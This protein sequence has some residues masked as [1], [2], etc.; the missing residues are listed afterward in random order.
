LAKPVPGGI[1]SAGFVE[2]LRIPLGK[3]T[4]IAIAHWLFSSPNVV[5]LLKLPVFAPMAHG[6][7][8]GGPDG[9]A[10][11][12]TQFMPQFPGVK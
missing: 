8:L 5:V 4:G 3:V 7:L 6:Q 12:G 11:S 9:K 2:A 1:E 10:G